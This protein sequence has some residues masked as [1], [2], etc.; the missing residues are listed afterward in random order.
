MI[1]GTTDRLEERLERLD[2]DLDAVTPYETSLSVYDQ[3]S[4]SEGPML[5]ERDSTKQCLVIC[6]Q[7][8]Q[9]IASS[10]S[11][12]FENISI[13]ADTHATPVTTLIGLI[14]ARQ[15]TSEALKACASTMDRT[16]SMLHQNLADLDSSISSEHSSSSAASSPAPHARKLLEADVATT[17]QT[18]KFMAEKAERAESPSINIYENLE[19]SDDCHT[20]IVSNIGQLIS[21]RYISAGA[22]STQWIGQMSDESIQT[23]AKT[24]PPRKVAT[25][26]ETQAEAG[27]PRPNFEGRYGVGTKLSSQ[28]HGGRGA[29]SRWGASAQE[30]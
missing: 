15:A 16:A 14:S 28:A 11:A 25:P 24:L 3:A 30:D 29:S 13:P 26:A 21:A 23:L 1:T 17:K 9:H 22:R 10:Q 20:V 2:N 7:V 6:A 8:S 4:N 12:V 19:L 5:Q 18:L 27:A